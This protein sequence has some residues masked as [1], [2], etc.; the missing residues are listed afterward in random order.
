MFTLSNVAV[1]EE[2]NNNIDTQV[3]LG[4]VIVTVDSYTNHSRSGSYE[5]GLKFGSHTYGYLIREFKT[6]PDKYSP[7]HGVT[8]YDSVLEMKKQRAG[9]VMLSGSVTKEFSFDT[10]QRINR[11]YDREYKWKA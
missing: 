9:K 7:D 1:V 10:I 6:R 11:E 3:L 5:R 2:Y 4:K 8:W